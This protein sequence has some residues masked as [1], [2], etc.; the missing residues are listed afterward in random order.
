MPRA[1]LPQSLSVQ[2]VGRQ[3]LALVDFTSLSALP[4][5][6]YHR[7]AEHFSPHRCSA[8]LI[9]ADRSASLTSS[10]DLVGTPPTGHCRA[11]R[12]LPRDGCAPWVSNLSTSDPISQELYL[13]NLSPSRTLICYLSEWVKGI[14]GGQCHSWE[15]RHLEAWMGCFHRSA[16]GDAR[17]PSLTPG[18]S[19]CSFL[20]V[21]SA[22]VAN[23]GSWRTIGNA[24]CSRTKGRRVQ[25]RDTWWFTG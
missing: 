3:Y 18:V 12:A 20:M 23:W 5:D 11:W 16:A 14:K 7:R 4:G 15:E 17:L 10:H 22:E 21:D 6:Y 8:D 25:D 2:S 9:S 1:E 19:L 13:L 24:W